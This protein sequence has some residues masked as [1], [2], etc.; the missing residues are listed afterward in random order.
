VL[1]VRTDVFGQFNDIEFN[2]YFKASIRKTADSISEQRKLK[3]SLVFD[4]NNY[5]YNEIQG[6]VI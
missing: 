4:E 1:A 3:K 6:P 2:K 5:Y